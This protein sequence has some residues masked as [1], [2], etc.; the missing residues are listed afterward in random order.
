MTNSKVTIK[1]IADKLNLSKS[2][3]S[4]AF[5]NATDV[6]L[7]TKERVLTCASELG[8]MVKIKKQT[9]KH[10][11][12][13]FVYGIDIS[14]ME[15]FGYEILLGLQSLA[16][17]K[18]C[19]TN[20]VK[21]N[22]E[23]LKDGNYYNY[24]NDNKCIGCFFMG[25]RPHK[26]FVKNLSDENLPLVVLDN[27]FNYGNVARIG[28]DHIKGFYNITKY[29]INKGHTRIA[30]FGGEKD[31]IITIERQQAYKKALVNHDVQIRPDLIGYGHFNGEGTKAVL[32]KLLIHK[33]TAIACVSDV[34]ANCVIKE[35]AGMNIRVPEDISVTG[36]D[37]IPIAQYTTPPLTTV[38]QNRLHIGKTA[39][40]L[41]MQMRLGI[42]FSEIV[43]KPTLIERESVKEIR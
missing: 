34:I 10:Y 26:N 12:C 5:S 33:P 39:F 4:K 36:Y 2:T 42:S 35:L 21:I 3:V 31:S 22:D 32:Q 24:A 7:I 28:C 20:I 41:I 40:N 23:Q 9:H 37:D 43:L 17:E 15:Q 16:S 1:D 25:F 29:I 8:Y 30:F 6:N 14:S 38:N 13:V 27:S 19:L 11:I 18:S